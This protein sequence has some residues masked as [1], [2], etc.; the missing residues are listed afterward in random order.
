MMH[1]PKKTTPKRDPKKGYD[2]TDFSEFFIHAPAKEQKK[3]IKLA[4]KSANKQQKRTSEK[5][6]ARYAN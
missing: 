5:A 2:K 1:H 4:V 3:V 6:K